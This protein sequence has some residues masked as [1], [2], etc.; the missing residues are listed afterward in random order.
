MHLDAGLRAKWRRLKKA[1]KFRQAD[2]DLF[3]SEIVGVQHRIWFPNEEQRRFVDAAFHSRDP[4][5]WISLTR[6]IGRS[7]LRAGPSC[8]LGACRA[9]NFHYTCP[10]AQVRNSRDRLT[11]PNDGVTMKSIHQ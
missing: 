6:Y 10:S 2:A 5:H 1:A 3:A 7:D 4:A 9:D 11:S 8:A